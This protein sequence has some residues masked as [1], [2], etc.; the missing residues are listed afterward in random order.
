MVLRQ[1]KREGVVLS[2]EILR[3]LVCCPAEAVRMY[4]CGLLKENYMIITS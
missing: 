3:V 2:T 1:V 4:E